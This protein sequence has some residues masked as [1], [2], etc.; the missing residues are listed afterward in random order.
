MFTVMM[1]LQMDFKSDLANIG[2]I[3]LVN[4]GYSLPDDLPQDD[5]SL[6]YLNALRRRV[7]PRPRTLF[8]S[9]EF[10]CPDP[11]KKGL[12]LLETKVASGGDLNPHLSR[13]IVKLKYDDALLNDWHIY[14]FHLG[15]DF[16]A[17]GLIKGTE[18]VLFARVTEECFY[19]ISMAGH[20]SWS[21]TN[22]IEV[23]HVNWPDSIS[24]FRN[25]GVTGLTHE[26]NSHDIE[27]LRKHQINVGMLK[28]ADGTFYAQPGGGYSLSG[29]STAV[30]MHFN[31]QV[32]ELRRLEKSVRENFETFLP[33][34]AKHGYSEGKPLKAEFA[35]D[36]SGRYV[37]FKAYNVRSKV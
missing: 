33:E 24:Q 11:L 35:F 16:M 29:M 4:M 10:E 17:N 7:P 6:L 26:F 1:D 20:G 19:E 23:L 37:E 9:R 12:E 30:V 34:L 13:K 2:R 21:D 27:R 32:H 14:H 3:E 28:T 8:R 5:V 25:N 36:D 31:K 15:T 22:L 18:I